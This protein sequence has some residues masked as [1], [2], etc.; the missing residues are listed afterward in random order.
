MITPTRALAVGALV[1]GVVLVGLLMFDSGDEYT[2]KAKFENAGQV[3]TGGLVEIAGK[4]VGTI[5]D[6]KLTDDGLAEIT[7]RIDEEWTPIPRGTHAQIRQFG[8]SGPASRYVELKLPHGK[9]RGNLQDG[10]EL[11]LDDTTGHVDLD[12]IFKIFDKR[13]RSSLRGVFRGSARQY[14]GQGEAA[15]KGWI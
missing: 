12:T 4:K 1:A 15:N 9:R 11:G 3:V 13:T 2:I 5:T 7:L 8:L 10:G 14:A 6:Q